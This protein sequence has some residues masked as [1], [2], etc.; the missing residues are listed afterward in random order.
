MESN[1][2]KWMGGSMEEIIQGSRDRAIWRRS[3][4]GAAR[5][6]DHHSGLMGPRKTENMHNQSYTLL[7]SLMTSWIMNTLLWPI[8]LN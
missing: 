8:S 6:A 4:R 3:V 1:L 7:H 5:A 2:T